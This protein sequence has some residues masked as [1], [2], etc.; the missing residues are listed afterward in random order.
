[1]LL[2]ACKRNFFAKPEFYQIHQGCMPGFPPTGRAEPRGRI[3]LDR[4][5]P[6][7]FLQGLKCCGFAGAVPS[8]FAFS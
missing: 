6:F 4:S 5:P 1:M 8:V 3:D 2:S 7:P